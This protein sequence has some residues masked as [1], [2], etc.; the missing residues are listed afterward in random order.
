[1]LFEGLRHLTSS[2]TSGSACL[3]S[4]R[5]RAR[6]APRQ[7]M[8]SAMRASISFAAEAPL[9]PAFAGLFV[10]FAVGIF[11]AVA[12]FLMVRALASARAAPFC[13]VRQKEHVEAA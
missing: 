4:S 13:D 8:R 1:M 3:M 7:S 6:V 11:M 2:V 5:R 12:F 10:F 9:V